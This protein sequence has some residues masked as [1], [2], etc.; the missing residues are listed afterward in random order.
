[1]LLLARSL[2]LA[3]ASSAVP[4]ASPPARLPFP[5]PHVVQVTDATKC[6]FG[7]VLSIDAA[8]GRMQ[9][10]TRAGVVTYVVGPDVQVFSKEGKPVGGLAAV[11]A[12][13]RYRAYYV[14]DQGARVQEIDLE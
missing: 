6:D 14:I 7:T 3:L 4:A 9:G 12:G 8:R 11:T 2:A 1:M 5:P 10:T 13:A